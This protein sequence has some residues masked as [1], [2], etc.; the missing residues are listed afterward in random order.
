MLADSFHLAL[1]TL[2]APRS[3]LIS[4]DSGKLP[5]TSGAL[6]KLLQAPDSTGHHFTGKNI[7]TGPKGFPPYPSPSASLGRH[8]WNYQEPR[9]SFNHAGSAL[10]LHTRTTRYGELSEGED[11]SCRA[12]RC[13]FLKKHKEFGEKTR[14]VHKVGVTIQKMDLS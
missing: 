14:G 12:R 4:G 7:T 6:L 2:Q 3:R 13:C 9:M 10:L 11:Y 5:G 8:S 1:E